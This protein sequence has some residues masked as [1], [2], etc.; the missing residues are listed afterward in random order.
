MVSILREG[1][2][3]GQFL[4]RRSVEFADNLLAS[5]LHDICIGSSI[6]SI[7]CLVDALQGGARGTKQTG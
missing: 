6:Q 4:A 1:V 2:G 7:F 5:I 3:G